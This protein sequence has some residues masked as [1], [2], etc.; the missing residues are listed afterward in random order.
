MTGTLTAAQLRTGT[1]TPP[2][3]A[4]AKLAKQGKLY[5]RDRITLLLDEDSFVEDGQL[6]NSLSVGLPADGVVTG[7]GSGRRP[8]GARGRQRPDRQSR[9]GARSPSRR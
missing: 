1:L 6:A 9:S 8:P 7:Q 5:V 4:A 3:A 2:A